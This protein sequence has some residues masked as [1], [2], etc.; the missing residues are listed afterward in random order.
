MNIGD[1][2][3]LYSRAVVGPSGTGAPEAAALMNPHGEPMEILEVRFRVQPQVPSTAQADD[4]KDVLGMGIGVKMDLGNV[5]VVNGDTPLSVFG[6]MRDTYEVTPPQSETTGRLVFPFTYGWRLQHPLFVSPGGLL[7]PTFSHLGQNSYPVI[8]DTAYFCRRVESKPDRVKVPWVSR[9]LS[10][11]FDFVE[12]AVA[13]SDRS[14]TLDLVNPFP[15]PLTISRLS[16]RLSFLGNTAG[17]EAQTAFAYEEPSVFRQNLMTVRIR[18]SRGMD[19][20]RT[21]APF[22]GLFPFNWRAWD[23][24]G[25]WQLRPAEFYS[26][27]LNTA[28]VP[29]TFVPEMTGRV[30]ASIGMIGH[31]ELSRSEMP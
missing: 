19:V 6:T 20:V 26:V 10:K 27:Y 24:P 11:S 31:R 21:A 3:V 22:D 16:G 5:P 28:A 30:Q 12:G 2:L 1:P 9:F 25:S 14:A 17:A 23:I 8:V 13:N 29:G 15:I 18:S 4:Y 7:R